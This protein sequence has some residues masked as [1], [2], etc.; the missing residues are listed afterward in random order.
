MI[1]Y[2]I[3][4][5]LRSQTARPATDPSMA[6]RADGSGMAAN[7]KLSICCEFAPALKRT[8]AAASVKSVTDTPDATTVPLIDK[9][10]VSLSVLSASWTVLKPVL[11]ELKL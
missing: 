8:P 6:A 5:F 1:F 10:A 11:P 3:L 7:V 9:S 4:F 2:A